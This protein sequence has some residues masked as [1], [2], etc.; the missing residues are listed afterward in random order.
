MGTVGSV[1]LITPRLRLRRTRLGDARAI[2]TGFAQDAEVTRYLTWQPHTDI[3]QTRAFLTGRAAAWAK[4]DDLTWAITLV[5]ADTCIGLIGLRRQ[6]FKADIGYV[7][8]RP[9]WGRGFMSEAARAVVDWAFADPAIQRVWATCDVDNLASARVLENV[10]MSREG[11]LRRW[12]MHP[13]ISATPC[14][15]F[16]Y[17]KVRGPQEVMTKAQ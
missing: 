6:G 11:T 2:F 1:E 10:G 13:Q 8:A 12:L 14:D 5:E 7:L 15:C 17:A 9:Y 16:C 3:S 4:G